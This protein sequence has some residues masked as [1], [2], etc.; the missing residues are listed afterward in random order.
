M[1]EGKFGKFL[2]SAFAVCFALWIVGAVSTASAAAASNIGFV[3]Y[4]MLVDYHPDT[5]KANEAIKAEAGKLK[6]EYDSKAAGMNEKDKQALDLE[7]AKRLLQKRQELTGPI[8]LKINATI[9][10]VADAKGL[11]IV[12]DKTAVHYGGVDITADVG[13]II[14]PN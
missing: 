8:I 6:K 7:M 5:Q 9:R 11:A 13:K 10:E 14:N 4:A 2:V 12:L 1:L 3:D